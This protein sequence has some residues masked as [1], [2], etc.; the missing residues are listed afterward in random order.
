MKKKFLIITGPQ[1]SGNHLFSRILSVHP[2]VYGWKDLLDFYW[3]PSDQ[4]SFADYWV[5]PEKLTED[6]FD[7]YNYFL[8]NVSCPFVYDGIRYVP[9]IVEVAKR[10]ESFGIDVQVGIIVRDQNINAKQQTRVRKEVT[11][12]IAQDYYYNY[13]IPS[14]IKTHFIDH[15]AFFL[16]KKHYLKWLSEILEF[17]I[18]YDNPDIMKFIN[19]DANHKYVKYVY[20]YWLDKE[21]WSGLRSKKERNL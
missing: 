7:S 11:L 15:E 16:H 18:D 9:K 19:Q 13:L 10:A 12:P 3:I 6:F 1:G 20:E 2:E 14:G 21:V 8:G 4:E 17:P 5:D